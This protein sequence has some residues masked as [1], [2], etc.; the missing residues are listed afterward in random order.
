MRCWGCPVNGKELIQAGRLKEARQQLAAEVKA[1]PTDSAKRILLF[2]V[3]AFC[4]EWDKA[5]RHLDV[6]A[7][8]DVKAEVG[9]QLYKSLVAAEREREA[10][11][12]L[13]RLPAILPTAPRYL[14][15]YLAA[16]RKLEG[17]ELEEATALYRQADSGRRHVSGHADGVPFGDFRDTDASL[18]FFLEAMVHGHYVWI[19]FESLRELSISAPKTLMDLLWSTARITTG[20]GLVMNCCLPVLYPGSSRHADD[21]VRLGRMTDWVPLGGQF[22]QGAG[23]HV[24]RVGDGETAILEIRELVFD[25]PRA[26][27][28][29]ERDD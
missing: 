19:P 1:A 20:E 17:K 16:R 13:E 2:Q 24:F 28:R 5:E 8:Q 11:F 27:D 18:E 10:V 4:G 26:G 15:T 29:D 25:L 22:Y 9:V 3:L 6:I 14:D 12:S 21:R 7:S 23:Q